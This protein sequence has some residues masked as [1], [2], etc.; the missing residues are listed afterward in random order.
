M[1]GE[2][3]QFSGSGRSAPVGGIIMWS[4]GAV[5]EHWCLCDGSTAPS[6][7][8]TPNLINQNELAYIMRWK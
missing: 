8:R 3:L 4:G 2:W 5:P 1:E 7:K 6:G